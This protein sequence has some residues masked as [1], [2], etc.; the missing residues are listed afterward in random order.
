MVK[1]AAHR[2]TENNLEFSIPC[3]WSGNK[4]CHQIPPTRYVCGYVNPHSP[5]LLTA[6]H[7][8]TVCGSVSVI[9]VIS[10]L[11][12]P[13]YTLSRPAI[14][15]LGWAAESPATT[16]TFQSSGHA[17]AQS[18]PRL[19]ASVF[20]EAPSLPGGASAQSGIQK[21]SQGNLQPDN[22]F[23]SQDLRSCERSCLSQSI[24]SYYVLDMFVS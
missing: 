17:S 19:T 18:I 3:E 24:G 11:S 16:Y 23:R 2:H 8:L 7:R 10:N 4:A 22:M 20:S 5:T 9:K 6:C 1:M 12:S 14:L 21:H 15:K 13:P